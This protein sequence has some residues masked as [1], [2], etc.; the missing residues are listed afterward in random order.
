MS[1][2][3]QV[4]RYRAVVIKHALILYAETGRKANRMYT[5]TNML[6]AATSITGKTYKRGQYVQ[7]AA[8]IQSV[9]DEP[10]KDVPF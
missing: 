8:D 1:I 9:L 5:P 4:S 6:N 10:F 7:A 2:N 3:P